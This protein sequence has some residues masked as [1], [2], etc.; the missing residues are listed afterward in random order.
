MF[1]NFKSKFTRAA[2]ISRFHW[3]TVILKGSFG[4]GIFL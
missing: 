4:A 1:A 3:A 2:T